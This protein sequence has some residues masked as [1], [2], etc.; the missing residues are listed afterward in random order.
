MR[1]LHIVTALLVAVAIYM[2]V[3]QRDALLEFA[4]RSEAAEPDLAVP[5]TAGEETPAALAGTDEGPE[6]I[7][8]VAMESTAR[9]IDTAVLVRGRTEAARQVDV[10]AETSGL[11]INDPLRKGALVETG[12]LL[13][14]IAPG[15]RQA[16]LSEARARLAEARARVPEAAARVEEAEARLAEAEINDRAARSLNQS[17]FAAETRVAATAAGVSSARAGLESART[18]LESAES[19]VQSAQAAVASAETEIDRLTITA[20]FGGLLESDTA[21]LGALMQPGQVCATVI[22]LNPIHLVGFVPEAEVERVSMGA[23][24][25]ARLASGGALSGRVSYV[26]RSADPETRTFQVEITVP[27]EDLS[28][29]DGQTADIAIAS[30][31]APA[32]LVPASALTLDDEGHLGLRI[33]A[34]DPA[35][36]DVAAFTEIELV[37]DT[38]NGVYVT[39][40][41]DPARV[42]IIGQEFVTD[43]V[44]LDVTLRDPFAEATQ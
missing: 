28:V 27:N 1:V 33:A 22:Q 5:A 6:R 31:G 26:S 41:P 9:E 11:I 4:G 25:T 21:E 39:G 14:E 7:R 19:A 3:I 10:R 36:G 17:G 13:C 30:D 37:R 42:I 24:A 29:R 18:G 12:D 20:P 34:S 43:G 40:L 44:P 2:I 23:M 38:T 35:I 32:H 16:T 15:T 8:I